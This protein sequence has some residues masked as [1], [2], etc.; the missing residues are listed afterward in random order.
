[1]VVK[2]ILAVPADLYDGAGVL[3]CNPERAALVEELRASQD[4]DCGTRGLSAE[5]TARDFVAAGYGAVHIVGAQRD[6]PACKWLRAACE[7][8]G[9]R[10]TSE[11]RSVEREAPAWQVSMRDVAPENWLVACQLACEQHGASKVRLAPPAGF[12]PQEL[13][14]RPS[15]LS[16][17]LENRWRDALLEVVAACWPESYY[18][19]LTL[20]GAHEFGVNPI[21]DMYR[22]FGLRERNAELLANIVEPA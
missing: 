17:A 3:D 10:A 11:L 6:V 8:A 1:M 19:V 18:R 13:G 9:L 21:E 12:E 22:G 7:A 20:L 4:F 5:E 16:F 14:H 2:S 15:P